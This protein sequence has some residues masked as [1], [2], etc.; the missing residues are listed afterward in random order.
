MRL[1]DQIYTTVREVNVASDELAHYRQQSSIDDNTNL[2]LRKEVEYSERM[3]H[4]QKS[5]SQAHYQELARLRDVQFGLD[6]DLDHL[7]K[8]VSILRSDI[9][10]NDQRC[11][12]CQDLLNNKEDSIQRTQ[13]K[14]SEAN[15]HIQELK[16]QLNKLDGE[17]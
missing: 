7:H 4:E 9:E 1:I 13:A 17:L 15:S 12:Q 14:V 6:K 11:G 3:V 8:R 16:Y 2:S 10:N 5:T